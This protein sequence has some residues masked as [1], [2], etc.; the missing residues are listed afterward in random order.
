MF[1]EI[2][3]VLTRRFQSLFYLL[4]HLKLSQLIVA[5][6]ISVILLGSQLMNLFEYLEAPILLEVA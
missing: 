1:F 6:V 4:K 2:E 3:V 5:F